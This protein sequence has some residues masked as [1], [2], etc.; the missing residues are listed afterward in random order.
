[1]ARLSFQESVRLSAAHAGPAVIALA[2]VS[3]RDA[4]FA[5]SRL[6]R[7]EADKALHLSPARTTT[8]ECPRIQ[9]P[10]GLARLCGLYRT[11]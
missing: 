11:A 8:K 5:L 4:R 1:M 7:C 6:R 3:T 2:A 10:R 9:V